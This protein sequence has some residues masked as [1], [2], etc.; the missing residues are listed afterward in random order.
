MNEFKLR[1]AGSIGAMIALIIIAL[2]SI[3]Y[4]T[5]Q[6]ESIALNKYVLTEKNATVEEHLQQKINGYKN[7]LSGVE[8]NRSDITSTGLSDKAVTQLEML[9]RTQS[10]FIEG[11]YIITL[12][13]DIYNRKGK[14]QNFNVKA[15]GRSYYKALFNQ[16]K[17]FYIS[18]PFQSAVTNNEVVTMAYKTNSE[19]AVIT[20]VY[21]ESLL[22]FLV[23]RDDIFLYTQEGTILVAP[24][25]QLLG[26]DIFQERAIYKNFSANN[27]ELSYD[28]EVDG[29]TASFTAFW[30]ELEVAGWQFVSFINN[31]DIEKGADKQLTTS[32]IVGALSLM[33]ALAILLFTL[34]KLV[35]KPVGGTPNE[36]ATLMEK[37]ASGDFTHR[38]KHTGK[39]TGIYSSLIKL[40]NQLLELIQNTRS[41]SDSV[42]SASEQLNVIMNDSK[43][44]ANDELSQ[45]EQISTAINELSSTSQEVSQQAV[46]AEEEAKKAQ[47][48]V[49]VGQQNL[50]KNIKLTNEIDSSVNESASI[51]NELRQFA[52]EIGS[53]IEVINSISEQTNLLAL[54][55][56]IE[57]AR[58]GEHGRGFAV[59]ADEV[60]NLASKT[61][62]STVSIQE[63]IEKLQ[64]QSE[65]AHDNMSQNV[66]LIEQSVQLAENIKVSFDDISA[67]AESISAIN[68]MVATAA[69]EQFSV[70]EDISKNTTSAFDLVQQNVAGVDET[71]QASSELAK[72]AETQ[73]SELDFFTV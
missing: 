39:E 5:F 66:E 50:E 56:A 33:L 54:N 42:S 10:Q 7:T 48:N 29:D 18:A 60:R 64:K 67:S 9:Y 15:L 63:I 16:G 62:D 3:A 57:A 8:A 30:T 45:V 19:I 12:D 51:V 71:L 28:T 61:Q 1:V 26:R 52:V 32:V 55:A 65:R 22:D 37:M 72:L 49:N 24:Y 35:L 36:I 44:N 2:C 17:T 25:K 53:V 58:A 46:A 43:S 27:P 59:V 41:I 23:G 69:Q 70:T 47:H 14:K 21:L 4:F 68:T 73:K 40:S 6:E 13:G 20:T 11:A 34:N 38:I 31:D